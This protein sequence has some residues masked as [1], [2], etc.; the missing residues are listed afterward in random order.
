[1][2]TWLIMPAISRA[3][4][5]MPPTQTTKPAQPAPGQKKPAE[6]ASQASSRARTTPSRTGI[7]HIKAH[8]KGKGLQKTTTPRAMPPSK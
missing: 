2:L 5:Q 3:Q 7:R 4:T 6:P 8:G 1:M